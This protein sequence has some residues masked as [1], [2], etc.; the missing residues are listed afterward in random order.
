MV[1]ILSGSA[2]KNSNT[3]RVAKAIK[4]SIME[5]DATQQ[6]HIVDF[7][8][9]DIPSINQGSLHVEALSIWQQELYDAMRNSGLIFI[10]TP[11]YNWFPSA[12]IIQMIHSMAASQF[13]TAWQDKVFVTCGVSNGRGGRMP[14]VQL[15]YAINKIINVFDF[16]SIVSAKMF[17]AQF[18]P[19][20][21][22]ENGESLGNPIFDK[23][24]KTFVRY[25]LKMNRRLNKN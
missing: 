4:N 1:T 11:E 25:N 23:G 21:L 7:N 8:G 12:E 15:S 14:A 5:E 10:L 16:E 22:N 20:V 19:D 3:L 13:A 17:E 2:R 9:F 18:T 24:L 6:V